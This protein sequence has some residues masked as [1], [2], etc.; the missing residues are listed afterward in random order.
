MFV[1]LLLLALL[2]W[3]LCLVWLIGLGVCMLGFAELYLVGAV[4][5]L[6]A[7]GY[8]GVG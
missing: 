2:I 5:L 4:G 3:F 1:D 7:L 8:L 6:A